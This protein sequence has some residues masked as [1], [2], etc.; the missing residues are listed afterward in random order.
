MKKDTFVIT[1]RLQDAGSLSRK[2][3][4]AW[5]ESV[6]AQDDDKRT[7]ALQRGDEA[8][9]DALRQLRTDGV[10]WLPASAE[11]RE[12][13]LTDPCF[14]QEVDCLPI[15][16][17]PLERAYYTSLAVKTLTYGIPIAIAGYMV[18]RFILIA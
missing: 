10:D 2:A 6:R 12:M 3:H 11:E 13:L 17:R 5:L 14:T 7:E 18:G 16:F 9:L 1:D 8:W 15:D 4:E